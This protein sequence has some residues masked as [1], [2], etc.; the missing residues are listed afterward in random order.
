MAGS[1]VGDLIVP[2]SWAAVLTYEVLHG[3]SHQDKTT[4]HADSEAII[5][6]WRIEG[7]VGRHIS[8]PKLSRQK[9]LH[10]VVTEHLKTSAKRWSRTSEGV[11]G[12]TKVLEDM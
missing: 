2:L 12:Y 3:V 7:T 6:I 4:K 8:L 9:S 11:S 5:S 1:V 10:V